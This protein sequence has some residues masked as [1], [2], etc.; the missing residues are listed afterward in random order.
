[1]TETHIVRCEVEAHLFARFA[2][3]SLLNRLTGLKVARG[4]MKAAVGIAGVVSEAKEDLA[5]N[6]VSAAPAQDEMGLHDDPVS[7]CHDRAA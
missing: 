7:L 3:E 4:Q 1:M 6:S 2:N 5:A